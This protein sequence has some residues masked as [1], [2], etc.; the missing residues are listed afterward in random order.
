MAYKQKPAP[1]HQVKKKLSIEDVKS[2]ETESRA[3]VGKYK[4]NK[5][6]NEKDYSIE[7]G[8]ATD[9]ITARRGPD[10]NYLT[11]E[12]LDAKSSAA[13]ERTR[14]L[15]ESSKTVTSKKTTTPRTG[16]VTTYSSS[17]ARQMETIK[18][19]ASKAKEV[20]GKVGKAIGYRDTSGDDSRYGDKIKKTPPV[21][22]LK[23]RPVA[24]MK[25]C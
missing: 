17:P 1:F 16:T 6:L 13:A 18:K 8:A 11:K 4:S 15:N 12:E 14:K 20:V 19:I 3:A 25:S 22:Q 9:S 10:K 23:K 2:M 7:L 21:K 5:K 24:K